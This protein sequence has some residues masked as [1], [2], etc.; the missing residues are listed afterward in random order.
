MRAYLVIIHS[1]S[2]ASVVG[3]VQEIDSVF[4]DVCKFHYQYGCI[5]G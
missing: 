3:G 2:V 1:N 5:L 4:R